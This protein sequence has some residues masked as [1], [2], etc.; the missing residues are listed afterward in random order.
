MYIF[1]DNSSLSVNHT[2]NCLQQTILWKPRTKTILVLKK[3]ES[4]KQIVDIFHLIWRRKILNVVIVASIKGIPKVIGFN[5]YYDSFFEDLTEKDVFY[6]RLK[7]LNNYTFNVLLIREDDNTTTKLKTVN[8]ETVYG[9]KDGTLMS[10]IIEHINAK[11][12]VI[13]LTKLYG[14]HNPWRYLNKGLLEY[15]K[16]PIIMKY[17]ADFFLDTLEVFPNNDT[18]Y[19]YPYSRDDVILIVPSA[20]LLSKDQQLFK[21][22]SNGFY[23]FLL[24]F[25][26]VCPI[27]WYYINYCRFKFIDNTSSSN[28]SFSLILINNLGLLLGIGLNV[29]RKNIAENILISFLIFCDLII[30]CVFQSMLS[31]IMTVSDFE[32]E[33]NSLQDVID[34]DPCKV[35]FTYDT[36]VK[37]LREILGITGQTALL[38]KFVMFTP[39]HAFLP[40]KKLPTGCG[41]TNF[42]HAELSTR[43]REDFHPVKEHLVTAY[44]AFPVIKDSP[45]YDVLNKYVARLIESGLY[46]LWKHLTLYETL[47]ELGGPEER[48]TGGYKDISLYQVRAAMYMLIVGLV[49]SIFVFIFELIYFGMKKHNKNWT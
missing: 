1:I 29:I 44:I 42:E 25:V 39:T 3:Y 32:H 6:N 47:I 8:N 48:E 18:E 14:E 35:I 31:S 34:Y 9:G 23:Y 11:A 37:D 38:H 20:K 15:M 10:T 30:N 4:Q 43:V 46:K 16:L 33:V 28:N 36:I 49:I 13:S 27:I 19:L 22:I 2:L 24:F 17:K 26:L 41:T 45:Y 21:I 12:N 40:F 5:P 7:N